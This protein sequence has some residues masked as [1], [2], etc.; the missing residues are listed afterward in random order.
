MKK[1]LLTLLLAVVLPS[2][3]SAGFRG[4]VE[5]TAEEKAA[6][7]QH[8]GTITK[9]ARRHLEDI[10]KEHQTFHR[11]H[12]V[13][14]FYGDRSLSLNTRDK[15]IAALRAAGAPASLVDELKPTSCVGLTMQALAAGFN[16]PNDPALTRAWQKIAAYARANNLDGCSVLDAL[17][18][19]G[20]RIA[21]WNPSPADNARWDQQDGNRK[22]KGWHAYR[23]A[24]VMNRGNYY[25]NKVDDKSLLVGF[26]TTVP[27]EF[28]RTTFFVGVAHT[29]YHVFP[30]FVGDVIEAHSTRPLASVNNLEKNPFNPLANGGA[31]RWTPS[32]MYRSGLVGIPPK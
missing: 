5:F 4:S 20:W 26:G 30:G 31:P 12:G 6:H 2:W 9:V 28:R 24:T 19:L 8:I 32:E 27:A 13:S 1:L 3:A 10:W 11:K 15:R 7:A 22:S 23:Y 21:Y 18:K 14:K 25:F 29:G 16:K 17:Q